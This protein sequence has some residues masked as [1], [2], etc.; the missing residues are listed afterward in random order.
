[1]GVGCNDIVD[2]AH[3]FVATEDVRLKW[4]WGVMTSL[5]SHKFLL[6]CRCEVEVGVGCNDIVELAH[7]FVAT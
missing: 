5:N 1:M 4:E 7:M 6:L 3:I 2:L